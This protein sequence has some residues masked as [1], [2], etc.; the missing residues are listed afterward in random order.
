MFAHKFESSTST[1][2]WSPLVESQPCKKI[3]MVFYPS[4][5]CYKF[6]VEA[7]VE[8]EPIWHRVEFVRLT[9]LLGEEMYETN[10]ARSTNEIHWINHENI[11][12][13][14]SAW[15]GYINIIIN[16]KNDWKHT[17]REIVSGFGMDRANIVIWLGWGFCIGLQMI[18]FTLQAVAL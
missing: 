15:M 9:A 7:L 17:R 10:V 6:Y 18:N 3:I 1:K 11:S 16:I 5:E 8:L 13:V 2:I 12:T 14:L 4:F